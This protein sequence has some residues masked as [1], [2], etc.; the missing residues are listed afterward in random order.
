MR[1]QWRKFEW[2][3][4]VALLMFGLAIPLLLFL[5]RVLIPDVSADSLNYH[6]YLGFKGFNI[7]NSQYE[8]YPTGIHNFSPIL[9]MVGY[10]L[11]A[12]LGYRLGTLFSLAAIYLAILALYKLLRLFEPDFKI[13]GELG[14]TFLFVSSFLS[15][16][17]FLGIGSYYNDG[18]IA[19][20]SLWVIYWLFKFIKFGGNKNLYLASAM[21]S[22]LVWGKQTN[23]YLALAFGITLIYLWIKKKIGLKK[24]IIAVLITGLLPSIWYFK[25][26]QITG[27]PVFPFYNAIFKS[28]YF[29]S[30]SFK[31]TQFGGKDLWQKINWGLYSAFDPPRLGQV[32]DLFNDYKINIY[33]AAGIVGLILLRSGLAWFYVVLFIL[34]GLMFGYLRYG[35]ILEFLGGL[36][37]LLVYA[38]FKNNRWRYLIFLPL[39]LVLL[40]QNKRVVNM[41]LAYDIA[42]RQG[43]FY[44][45]ASYP[46]E[47][48]NLWVNKIEVKNSSNFKTDVYLNCAFGGMSY[49]VLSPFNN[50]PVLNVENRVYGSMTNNPKYIDESFDKLKLKLGNKQVIRFITI[51]AREGM[52]TEYG[53]CFNNL[54][55]KGWVVDG[56]TEATFL[57]YG[58]QKLSIITGYLDMNN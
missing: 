56:E 14:A 47:I 22:V 17:L 4:T 42:F 23:L 24:I 54:K 5:N 15:F 21:L 28:Q 49:Y 43:Y 38:K 13:L 3:G 41:S 9:D 19:A 11:N 32:H 25:N 18:L 31:E 37:L 10:G 7:D 12:I 30:V 6:L 8:F 1:L 35:L 34:W 51:A 27:N 58:P 57:H 26:W 40:V 46:K 2:W 29:E 48:N 52:N 55:S 39:M 53:T 50:L 16:E 36:I 45:R 33:W 20:T 44:N